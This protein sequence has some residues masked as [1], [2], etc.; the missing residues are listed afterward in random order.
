[1]H[2]NLLLVILEELIYY[3]FKLSFQSFFGSIK[4]HRFI[5]VSVVW[6]WLFS[7]LCKTK[8]LATT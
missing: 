1:M 8:T 6:Y 5:K 2:E 3:I 7:I 4:F